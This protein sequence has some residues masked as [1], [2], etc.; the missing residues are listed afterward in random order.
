MLNKNQIADLPI[1][2]KFPDNPDTRTL[3]TELDISDWDGNADDPDDFGARFRAYLIPP[4]SG[5]FQFSLNLQT[6]AWDRDGEHGE[7]YLSDTPF[8]D[9][10][11]K[12][13]AY[14]NVD[15]SDEISEYMELEQGK[16]YY[17][18]VFYK[19]DRYG[20]VCN[21][22]WKHH[23]DDGEDTIIGTRSVVISGEYMAP[24]VT[25]FELTEQF[26]FLTRIKKDHLISDGLFFCMFNP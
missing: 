18:D 1:S 4:E 16:I 24:Y 5:L 25:D 9:E 2:G 3:L 22:R 23:R 10:N 19:E 21:V 12:L 15:G 7:L 26:Y 20:H 8:P 11:M 6:N 17:L 14:R 13:I